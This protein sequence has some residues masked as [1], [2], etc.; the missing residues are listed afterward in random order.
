MAHY[1][2]E[3]ERLPAGI[4]IVCTI[5]YYY[6]AVCACGHENFEKPGEGYVSVVEGRK[7]NVKLTEHTIVGPML[8]AT[9][10][11]LV[12]PPERHVSE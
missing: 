7:R 8:A 5:H 11:A 9:F 2:Y 3:L 12:E 10:I 4:E 1:T 6:A